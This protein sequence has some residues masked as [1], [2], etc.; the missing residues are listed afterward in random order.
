MK[1][2]LDKPEKPPTIIATTTVR[3]PYLRPSSRQE[4]AEDVTDDALDTPLHVTEHDD[5]HISCEAPNA[6]L[7]TE[8]K[9][10][11]DLQEQPGNAGLAPW[12]RQQSKGLSFD[13]AEILTVDECVTHAALYTGKAVRVTGQLHQRSLDGKDA[14]RHVLLELIEPLGLAMTGNSSS[15]PQP[16]RT[17]AKTPLQPSSMTP[18]SRVSPINVPTTTT[19][20]PF[21]TPSKTLGPRRA[22]PSSSNSLFR[23]SNKRPGPL[24]SSTKRKKPWFGVP[25][26]SHKKPPPPPTPPRLVLK[27]LVDPLLPG[28]SSIAP[29]GA[30]K[31]M[32]MGTLSENGVLE[33]RFVSLLPPNTDMKLYMDGLWTRRRF[34]F[35][36][37]YH[38]HPSVGMGQPPHDVPAGNTIVVP[39]LGCGPPPYAS[40]QQQIPTTFETANG[41]PPTAQ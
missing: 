21:K 13:P 31:V 41:T 27:V 38:N 15:P 12:E 35:H 37:Y 39:L 36:R 40:L 34:L 20:T 19:A 30:S 2:D 33:A 8:E 22:P 1:E 32:V 7:L 18:D 23:S 26:S 6:P 25:T 3:N 9:K 28:I 4:S 24:L 10:D 11:E 17:P 29:S 5:N 16:T 14:T